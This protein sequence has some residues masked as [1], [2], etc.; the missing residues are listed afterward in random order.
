MSDPK[1][2]VPTTEVA[3][4]AESTAIAAYDSFLDGSSG[5]EDFDSGDFTVPF[6]G[7]LQALSKPLQRNHEK[8]IEGAAAGHIVNSATRASHDVFTKGIIVIPCA[9]QHRYIAWKPDN[10]GIAYDHGSDSKYY[11]SVVP[12]DKNKRIDAEGN[13][14]VDTM[15]YFCLQVDLE[16]GGFEAVVIPFSGTFSKKAKRW[17]NLIRT[18]TEMKDGKPIKPPIFFYSYEVKTVPESNAKGSW[19]SW[20]ISMFKPVPELVNGREIFAAA[21]ELRA[22]VTSGKLRAHTESPDETS[23]SEDGEENPF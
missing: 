13:E 7:I 19:Y 9:F 15:E 5:H 16:T 21:K 17:N 8:F 3:V 23:T 6:L 2:K 1:E 10:G 14:L 20:D 22:S 4:K 12:N 11:D 18:Q